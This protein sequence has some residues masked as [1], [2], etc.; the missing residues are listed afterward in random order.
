MSRAGEAIE[1]PLT[2]ERIVFLRT[3]AETGGELLEMDDF[4]TRPGQRAP[5]HVHPGMEETWQV[6]AGRAG[7]R[8]GDRELEAGPGET[9][10]APAGTPH[11]AWNASEGE[12]H[13]RITMRPALRWEEF[14]RRLFADP[15]R[16]L[17]LLREF[18]DEIA[19]A[20]WRR[21]RLDSNQRPR[22]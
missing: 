21:P 16:G 8:I 9:V 3:A 1:N 18:P 11:Q 13:L 6:I 7:F 14:V 5:A 2:G 15:E 12:T 4:W 10:V 17:E 22:D 19:L 20:P